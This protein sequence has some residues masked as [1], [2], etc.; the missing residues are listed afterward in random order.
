MVLENL[1]LKR[2]IDG[3]DVGRGFVMGEDEIR[4][5][6]DHMAD[7]REI[8][9]ELRNHCDSAKMDIL[10]CMGQCWMAVPVVC[11]V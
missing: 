8:I 5:R 6:I 3:Y 1:E 2:L 11:G 7:R 10:K 9:E 4:S